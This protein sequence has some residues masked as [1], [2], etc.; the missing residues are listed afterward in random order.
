MPLVRHETFALKLIVKSVDGSTTSTRRP[1]QTRLDGQIIRTSLPD[2]VETARTREGGTLTPTVTPR[3]LESM[4][5]E[6]DTPTAKREFMGFYGRPAQL[7]ILVAEALTAR[8]T[9]GNA[10]NIVFD[11][12]KHTVNGRITNV[13]Q[14]EV[15]PDG[16]TTSTVT[17]LVEGEYQLEEKVSGGSD[18]VVLKV[19]TTGYVLQT[20]ANATD[21]LYNALATA[22]AE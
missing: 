6:F 8:A 12:E 22:L 4:T 15:T 10:G 5:L 1:A 3:G 13:V 11:R 14:G 18:T 2:I 16:D 7:V 9:T 17:F 20:G 19:D 21:N